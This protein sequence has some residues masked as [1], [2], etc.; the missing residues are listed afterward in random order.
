MEGV[1]RGVSDRVRSEGDINWLFNSCR[2]GVS[3]SLT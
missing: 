1:Y 2:F 3:S